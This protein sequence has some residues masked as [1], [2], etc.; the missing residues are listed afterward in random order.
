MLVAGLGLPLLLLGL[1]V[2]MQQLEDRVLDP[3]GEPQPP[4]PRPDEGQ[5]PVVPA[6]ATSRAGA[7]AA[8]SA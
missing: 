1:L 4:P 8:T 3:S 2:A 7:A 5:Q 6:P